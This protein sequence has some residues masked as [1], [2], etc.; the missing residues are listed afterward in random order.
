MSEHDEATRDDIVR[1]AR[2]ADDVEPEGELPHPAGGTDL[3]DPADG[4]EGTAGEEPDPTGGGDRRDEG[5]DRVEDDGRSRE[6]L[7]TALAEAET[8]R[9]EYLDD[10]RR[11]QAEFANYRKR[12]MREGAEQR[13]QGTAEVLSKLVDVVDDFELAVLASENAQDLDSLRRGVEMVYGKLIDT[14]RSFGLERI[15]QEGVPFDPELHD[16]VQKE[17]GEGSDDEPIVVE[18]LRPGYAVGDRVL[19]AAMVKVRT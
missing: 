4:A 17:E 2:E 16:A 19:R 12:A 8:A 14:L 13:E 5:N 9:D 18:V 7:L 10:L 6:D 3:D 11:S 1:A 15:G